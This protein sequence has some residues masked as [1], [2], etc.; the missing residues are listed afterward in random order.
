MS[1]YE[2]PK[3]VP[4]TSI[5]C[6]LVSIDRKRKKPGVLHILFEYGACIWAINFGVLEKNY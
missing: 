6:E 1:Q 3:L 4:T 2:M 5:I